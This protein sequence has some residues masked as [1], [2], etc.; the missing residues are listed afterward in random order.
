MLW[1]EYPGRTGARWQAQ[2]PVRAVSRAVS[3]DRRRRGWDYP[4]GL[5]DN[6]LLV[7]MPGVEI[8]DVLAVGA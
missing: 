2:K 6:R 1:F 4:S 8:Y 3:E 7:T 5:K